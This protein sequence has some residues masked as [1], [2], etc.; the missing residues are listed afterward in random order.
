MLKGETVVTLSVALVKVCVV[1]R[2]PV[3]AY[4][5]GELGVQS[6]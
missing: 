1:V 5:P 4:V 2:A 6:A 3:Q